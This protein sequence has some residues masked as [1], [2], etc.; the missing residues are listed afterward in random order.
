MKQGKASVLAGGTTNGVERAFTN[1]DFQAHLNSLGGRQETT[2]FATSERSQ[3]GITSQPVALISCYA[4][5]VGR[6][7]LH[8]LATTAPKTCA[9]QGHQA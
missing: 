8:C 1:I 5:W 2:I 4:V 3:E 9:F 7:R 6:C